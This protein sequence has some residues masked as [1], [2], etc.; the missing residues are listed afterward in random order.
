MFF[1]SPTALYTEPRLTINVHSSDIMV[2]YETE[3]FPAPE[4][5]WKGENGK[6]LSSHI[7]TSIQPN[8]ETGLYY[9][10]S[11]YTAPKTPLNFTFTLKNQLMQQYLHRP[12]SFT[13][14]DF[15]YIDL[16]MFKLFFFFFEFISIEM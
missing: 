5:T 6:N 11:S 3:G 14:K 1:F 7:Q 13:G 15:R 10:K 2:Q 8:E 12:V 16:S 9:I 4:V